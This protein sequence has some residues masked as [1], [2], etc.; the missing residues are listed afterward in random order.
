MGLA[1]ECDD[2]PGLGRD[3]LY[4]GLVAIAVT[5]AA[6]ASGDW[7]ATGFVFGGVVDYWIGVDVAN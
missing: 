7:L 1:T 3:F 5:P 2:S 4:Y 6:G